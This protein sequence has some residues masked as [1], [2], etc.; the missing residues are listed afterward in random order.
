MT[1]DLFNIEGNVAIVTGG[2]RGLGKAMAVGLAEAGCNVVI[3]DISD[4]SETVKEI[5]NAGFK[6]IDIK[7]DVSQPD[8]VEKMVNK[9]IEEFGHIDILINNA[10]ILRMGK[11]EELSLEDWNKV[12]AVNLTGQFLSAQIVARHMLKRG[13]GNIINIGS[14]AG[15]TGYQG[16]VVYSSAKAGLVMMTKT[17]A[18]EWGHTLRVNIICP[19]VFATDMTDDFLEDE[20]FMANLKQNVPMGR[21]ATADEL[22]GTVIYLA[23]KASSYVNGHELV[24][25][26]GWT[27]AL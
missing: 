8:D 1:S 26:G 18:A 10:G 22:V 5:Q 6:A 7:V 3:A 24:I 12:L 16:S 15:L 23:S 27:A 11:A 4:S 21:Y 17:L 9:T 20:E 14:I 2:S 13:K 19:G 25:D